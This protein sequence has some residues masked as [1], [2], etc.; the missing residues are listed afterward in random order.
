MKIRLLPLLLFAYW[1]SACTLFAP[2]GE[3]AETPTLRPPQIASATPFIPDPTATEGD[4]TNTPVLTP[5]ATG[6][7]TPDPT[8]PVNPLTGLPVSIPALLDRRPLAVKVTLMP[9]LASRPQWG[10]SLADIVWEYYQNGGISRFHAIYYGNNSERVGPVRSA[11]FFDENLIRMY[12]S[13][14]AYGSGDARVLR[15]F[16]FSEFASYLVNEFPAGC[17]PMCRIDPGG[18]NHLVANTADLTQYILDQGLPNTAQ[19]LEGMAFAA[20]RPPGGQPAAEVYVRFGPQVYHRW[21]FDTATGRYLRN[22]DT[23][24]DLGI[25]EDYAPLV[26]ALNDDQLSTANVVVLIVSHTYFSQ[27]PEIVEINLTGSGPAFAFRDG[28]MYE[29]RWSLPASNAVLTLV[30]EDGT[31]FPYKPGNTWYTVIGQSSIASQPSADAWRWDFRI[32]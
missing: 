30:N 17:G 26:D 16:S 27:D 8:G 10:L 12:K 11:R 1:L 19:N 2:S 31:P 9:R 5:E 18:S 21:D 15:R 28:Q 25:G 14:F 6:S 20:Q 24:D 23:R 7:P 22:Q 13:I 3:P 32:P 29:V 4:P